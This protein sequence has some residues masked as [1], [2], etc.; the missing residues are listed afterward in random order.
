MKIRVGCDLV[1]LDK[2]KQ[3]LRRGKDKFL[4]KIFSPV[5]L[6]H[7]KSEASLAGIFAVKEAVIKALELKI[8]SWQEMEIIKNKKGRPEIRLLK[9]NSKIISQ[10]LSISHHGQYVMVVVVFLIR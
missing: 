9:S 6:L 5:E 2:F 3:S 8:G 4:E 1:D 7:N 10:D